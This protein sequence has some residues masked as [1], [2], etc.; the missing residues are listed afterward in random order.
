MLCALYIFEATRPISMKPRSDAMR[1][2]SKQ[3]RERVRPRLR[4]TPN[5]LAS[6]PHG[7]RGLNIPDEHDI[8]YTYITHFIFS[9]V[10][11]SNLN[12][13]TIV[14]QKWTQL[15]HSRPKSIDRL[16]LLS[17]AYMFN[18]GG[19]PN[20]LAIIA[21]QKAQSIQR[22]VTEGRRNLCTQYPCSGKSTLR[23]YRCQEDW[24]QIR[25]HEL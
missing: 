18:G 9:L 17:L 11:N 16:P 14:V 23:F 2:R 12:S 10:S 1:P 19:R 8:A 24:L 20:L 25:V 3:R 21:A 6:R 15:E 5:D 4:P 22:S 13:P 7:P